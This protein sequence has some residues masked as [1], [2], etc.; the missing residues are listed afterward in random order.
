M[1]ARLTF[2]NLLHP[3][4]PY[5]QTYPHTFSSKKV[6]KATLAPSLLIVNDR[7]NQKLTA[8]SM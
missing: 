1:G 5:S 4:F 8:W 6:T 2:R 7:I 3:K